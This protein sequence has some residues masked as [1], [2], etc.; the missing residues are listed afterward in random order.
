MQKNYIG[1][2]RKDRKIELNLLEPI[3]RLNKNYTLKNLMLLYLHVV[4][5]QT[6]LEFMIL[7]DK[8]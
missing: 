4:I 8:E 1:K 3:L 7:A 6:V 2:L 5:N